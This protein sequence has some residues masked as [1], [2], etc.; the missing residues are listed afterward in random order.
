MNKAPIWI[1]LFAALFPAV[2]PTNT[3][4]VENEITQELEKISRVADPASVVFVEVVS[5]LDSLA[6]PATPYE[7]SGGA[8]DYKDIDSVKVTVISKME[9]FPV[10]V[11]EL[12]RS[13][14]KRYT[15]KVDIK[16]NSK[17][18]DDSERSMA[19]EDEDS[20]LNPTEAQS[21]LWM[22]IKSNAIALIAMILGLVGFGVFTVLI[23]NLSTPVQGIKGAIEAGVS[24]MT[25][26]MTKSE[27]NK[28]ESDGAIDFGKSDDTEFSLRMI[29]D[30]PKNGALELLKDCYWSHSDNYAA[31]IWR[32]LK[33]SDAKDILDS[34]KEL[35]AY[36]RYLAN[37]PEV[38]HGFHKD[39]YYL[40]PLPLSKFS[41]ED[42]RRTIGK[43]L[44]LISHLSP[45]RM[46]NLK[47]SAIEKVKIVESKES[48]PK[49]LA[50]LTA[51]MKSSEPRR[52]PSSF[53][54]EVQTIDD[55]KDL[56]AQSGLSFQIKEQAVSWIWSKDVE[57]K[58]LEEIFKDY[59]AQDL[60]LA[61][62]G[63]DEILERL[64]TLVP[65]KKFGLMQSYMEKARPNRHSPVFKEIHRRILDSQRE[66]DRVIKAA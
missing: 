43:S 65:E 62:V 36:G 31:Y 66:V 7:L 13:R 37:L 42:L 61:W 24:Q 60:A 5:K 26:A 29:S 9:T 14:L 50:D 34:D 27:S 49:K 59:S 56:M 32:R 8:I 28:S 64:K 19:S 15:S 63:P 38:D 30:L 17:L 54:I 53:T 55:E 12:M 47:L 48:D 44:E 57:D 52:L 41:N 40:N 23:R 25:S 18:L 4:N 22:F 3:K 16:I 6:L 21:P 46:R 58:K 2:S 11:T 10:A 1:F 35:V 20:S 45:I 51:T 39:S 33:K